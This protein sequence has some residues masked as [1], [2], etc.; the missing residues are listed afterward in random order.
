MDSEEN[1]DTS[2]DN[3]RSQLTTYG[4]QIQDFL[5]GMKADIQ[6]YKFLIEKKENGLAVDIEFK[7]TISSEGRESSVESTMS[8]P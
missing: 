7:A 2:M 3:V 6:Q 8:N 5:S 4:S 1:Q